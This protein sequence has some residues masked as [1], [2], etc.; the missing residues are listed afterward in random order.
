MPTDHPSAPAPT[1]PTTYRTRCTAPWPCWPRCESGAARVKV[2]TSSSRNSSRPSTRSAPRSPTNAIGPA[3]V[4][5][6]AGEHAGPTGN[7][8]PVGTPHG[9]YP[10]AGPDNWCAIAVFSDDQW[11]AACSV[12]E[13][14]GWAD[15]PELGTVE[16]RRRSGPLLDRLIAS[17][18]RSWDASR[19]ASELASRGVAASPVQ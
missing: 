14:V 17:A 4:A 11:A 3:I 19:L 1:I 10:C 8:D 9:V 12:L 15:H 18:T 16:G 7:D 5:A 13:S 2:S 6:G